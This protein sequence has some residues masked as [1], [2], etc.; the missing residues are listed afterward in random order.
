MFYLLQKHKMSGPMLYN[1]SLRKWREVRRKGKKKHL[2]L[3]LSVPFLKN[4]VG[5]C[6]LLILT[7]KPLKYHTP[8]RFPC[9][10]APATFLF[11][12]GERGLTGNKMN[13]PVYCRALM[14]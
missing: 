8:S 12:I 2:A 1:L 14:C 6:A 13:F 11:C 5:R 10:E 4:G 3:P 9:Q 7:F